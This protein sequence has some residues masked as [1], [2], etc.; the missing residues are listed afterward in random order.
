VP[1]AWCAGAVQA[2]RVA[3]GLG[4]NGLGGF[5]LGVD[6]QVAVA[7][8]AV[9][10][11]EFE[12]AVKEHASAGR[13]AVVEAEG[14]LVEVVLQVRLVHRALVG[15]QQSSLGQGRDPVDSREQLA[16]VLPAGTGRALAA[17]IVGVAELV[18]AGIALPGIGDHGGA[19]LDVLGDEGVQ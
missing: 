14:E 2:R 15:A 13:S 9:S 7:D 11:G 4:R 17:P 12:D 18:D 3:V 19:G 1:G 8:R 6:D 5:G 16:G 10:D